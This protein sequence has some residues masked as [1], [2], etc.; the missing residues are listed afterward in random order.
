MSSGMMDYEEIPIVDMI[1][2]MG[3]Q[4]RLPNTWIQKMSKLSSIRILEYS[5]CSRDRLLPKG[6]K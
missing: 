2:N 4:L 3:I 5:L 6:T 1:W